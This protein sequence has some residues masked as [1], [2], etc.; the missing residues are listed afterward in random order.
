MGRRSGR[1]EAAGRSLRNSE[2][3]ADGAAAAPGRVLAAA[4]DPFDAETRRAWL[5]ALA[6]PVTTVAGYHAVAGR[7]PWLRA[8]SSVHLDGR[9][10]AVRAAIGSG[11]YAKIYEVQGV[12]LDR[13]TN[14]PT[15]LNWFSFS[16]SVQG[17]DQGA[18]NDRQVLKVQD[19]N[20]GLWEFYAAAELRRRLAEH[21]A[22]CSLVSVDH[23]IPFLTFCS[24]FVEF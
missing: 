7:V 14:R 6:E 4:F 20:E 23:G 22:A 18:A 10:Y 3:G 24:F 19:A 2:C 8:H 15:P 5:A 11:A 16:D 9:F 1:F 21:P 12:R 17:G 13:C